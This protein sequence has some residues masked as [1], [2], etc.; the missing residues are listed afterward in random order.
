MP[1]PRA[2]FVTKSFETQATPAV[3]WGQTL[4]MPTTAPSTSATRS[5]A[6]GLLPNVATSASRP[7]G[8]NG[9]ARSASAAAMIRAAI[10]ASS[11]VAR[12][13]EKRFV[14]IAEH[15]SIRPHG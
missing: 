13:N 2:L 10:V 5:C 14:P 4:T 8:S 3:S 6:S 11:G 12:R 7:S 15:G 1:S 9:S